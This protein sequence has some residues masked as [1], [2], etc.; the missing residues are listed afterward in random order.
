MATASAKTTAAATSH[1]L[2]GSLSP[3]RITH[4]AASATRNSDIASVVANAP[5][6][7]R[8]PAKRTRRLR[9]TRPAARTAGPRYPCPRAGLR[10]P[11]PSARHARSSRPSPSSV[12]LWAPSAATPSPVTRTTADQ[13]S[14]TMLA[15]TA[16]R[17][18]TRRSTSSAP[19]VL[20]RRF[21]RPAARS[22]QPH[23]PGRT[24]PVPGRQR[25]RDQGP[26]LVPADLNVLLARDWRHHA[27]RRAGRCAASAATYDGARRLPACQS[28]CVPAASGSAPKLRS[29]GRSRRL[30]LSS[31]KPGK[32]A[33]PVT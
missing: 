6:A 25:R 22:G 12:P 29:W 8:Y 19:P 20:A 28:S 5:G 16:S 11:S 32:P 15:R 21:R 10:V 23:R 18:L 31:A 14:A 3:A 30:R 17:P 27:G 13:L 1:P 2:A 33:R 9:R 4:Q 24:A 26:G 7:A